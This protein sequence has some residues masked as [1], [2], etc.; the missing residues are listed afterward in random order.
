MRFI[1]FRF[2]VEQIKTNTKTSSTNNESDLITDSCFLFIRMSLIKR[3]ISHIFDGQ[4][5]HM[6]SHHV[7]ANVV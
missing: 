1:S 5:V 4:V 6:V 7:H 2:L 3:F